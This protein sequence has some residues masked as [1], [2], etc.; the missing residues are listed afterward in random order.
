MAAVLLHP[1]TSPSARSGRSPARALVHPAYPGLMRRALSAGAFSFAFAFGIGGGGGFQPESTAFA[2]K[3]TKPPPAAFAAKDWK[4]RTHQEVQV[5][6]PV[7]LQASSAASKQ[8]PAEIKKLVESMDVYDS[9]G[10]P[11]TFRVMVIRTTYAKGVQVSLDGAVKGGMEKGAAAIGD[12]DAKP[13]EVE[14][15]KVSDLPARRAAFVGKKGGVAFHIEMLAAQKERTVWVVQV[16]HVGDGHAEA[17]ARVLDSV[18]IDADEK[19]DAKQP[20]AK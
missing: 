7:R 19:P 2:Q 5:E 10:T 12:A 6:S 18:L 13:F 9:G 20:E 14:E 3:E 16:I 11:P 17:A 4:K 15:V 8:L 1:S